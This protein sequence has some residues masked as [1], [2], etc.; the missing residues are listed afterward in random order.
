MAVWYLFLAEHDYSRTQRA[1]PSEGWPSRLLPTPA[2][3]V[4]VP[5]TSSQAGGCKRASS[6]VRDQAGSLRAQALGLAAGPRGV[7]GGTSLD[8]SMLSPASTAH[9]ALG[10][11]KHSNLVHN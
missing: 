10:L 9:L 11:C 8:L 1:D 4:S 6:W 7:L 2:F 3:V 5:T